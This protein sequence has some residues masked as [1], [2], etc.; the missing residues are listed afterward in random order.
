[1]YMI[2]LLYF[3]YYL[4]NKVD[5]CVDATKVTPWLSAYKGLDAL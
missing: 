4:Y 3:A 1:M 2:Y 5:V